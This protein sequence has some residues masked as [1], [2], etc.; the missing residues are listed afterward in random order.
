V[1]LARQW[2]GTRGELDLVLAGRGRG[3]RS[4]IVFCE[5]KARATSRFGGP[6]AAVGPA[7]QEAVRRT[8][9]EWL[10]AERPRYRAIRF[11]V[12]CVVGDELAV[13]EAAF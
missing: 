8:A 7:K 3:G 13:I 9:M 6:A 2:R 5:V 11:D 10:A 12:A 4:T 1:V